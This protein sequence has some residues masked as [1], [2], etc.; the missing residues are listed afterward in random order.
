M[1]DPNRFK[2]HRNAIID[3]QPS[4][5]FDVA[6]NYKSTDPF[7]PYNNV[8]NAG[9]ISYSYKDPKLS[10][11]AEMKFHL[12][13]KK[14]QDEKREQQLQTQSKALLQ[15]QQTFAL[16]QQLN[17]PFMYNAMYSLEN[18]SCANVNSLFQDKPPGAHSTYELNMQEHFGEF[19]GNFTQENNFNSNKFFWGNKINS[20]KREIIIQQNH[21]GLV[22][23]QAC[24]TQISDIN[25]TNMSEKRQNPRSF[26]QPFQPTGKEKQQQIKSP[27]AKRSLNSPIVISG[28]L[29]KQ[30]AEGLKVWRRRW[31]VLAE[32]CLFYYKNPEENKVLGSILLPSY[33]VTI[34]ATTDKTCKK[35][36]FKCEHQNM[37]T[38]WLGADTYESMIKWVNALSMACLM[39]S[40]SNYHY[41]MQQLSKNET[42]ASKKVIPGST[43]PLYVNAPPKPRRIV[44]E[45]GYH[46]TDDFEQLYNLLGDKHQKKNWIQRPGP[47]N[48]DFK[49]LSFSRIGSNDEINSANNVQQRDRSDDAMSLLRRQYEDGFEVCEG[50]QQSFS[51]EN[52]NFL[53]AD[54]SMHDVY[55]KPNFPKPESKVSYL[56]TVL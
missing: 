45:T 42:Y 40:N 44:G 11:P 39:K 24:Q 12:E 43:Q 23:N 20:P 34:C 22:V 26:T 7:L 15:Q 29:Y 18:E 27:V 3:N 10:V 52:S 16:R 1:A 55:I 30:G 56:K 50:L 19:N 8:N 48:N 21:P 33:K 9:S 47:S 51:M 49:N 13:Y 37:R 46:T 6:A 17:P 4:T 54:E 53:D 41:N 25:N 28:W 31:F 2:Y 14:L 35:F 5:N 36:T 32:Y 38:Y